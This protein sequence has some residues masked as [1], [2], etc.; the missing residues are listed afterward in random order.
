M[1]KTTAALEAAVAV[2][3]AAAPAEGASQ[4]NRQR[5]E[6]DRAFA[7]ILKL[8]APRIRHFIRQYGL[9]AHWDDAEQCCAIGVHRAIQAYDPAKAQ[10]TTFVNWQLRGELQ[11]L[12]FRLMT[13]QR[14]SA[15]KV[16]AT[17][18]SLHAGGIGVDGEETSLE[19]MIV[20]EGALELTESGASAYM[21]AVTRSKLVEEYVD[22]LR[23]V[24][25]EQMK[26]RAR[27]RATERPA[28]PSVPRL[29]ASLYPVDPAEAAAIEEK[30]A[31]HRE[32]IMRRLTDDGDVDSGQVDEAA[33]ERL[34]QVA[35]RATAAMADLAS[36]TPRFSEALANPATSR[37]RRAATAE[38]AT[39]AG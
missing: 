25:T 38:E 28:D 18:V 5:V 11:A 7:A 3:I 9:V 36:R 15:K 21:A 10:F 4:T 33:R 24:G 13:D 22:H 6:S 16:A 35:K 34:R 19:S 14:Q 20:D 31:L 12:R 8:I 26:R 23:V 30:V 2:V 29:K 27:T 37:W 1:S 17:T 39:V 32:A